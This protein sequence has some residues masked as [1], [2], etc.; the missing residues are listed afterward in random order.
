MWRGTFDLSPSNP[1]ATMRGD[2]NDPTDSSFD[3]HYELEVG[4]VCRGGM[5]RRYLDWD[6]E[7]GPGGVWLCGMWEPHGFTMTRC[8]CTVV[9]MVVS[10]EYL[11]SLGPPGHDWLAPFTATARARPVLTEGSRIAMQRIAVRIQQLSQP[12]SSARTAW[13]QTCL[14]DILLNLT[15]GWCAPE[16]TDTD[17]STLY[18]RL[19]P[20]TALVFSSRRLVTEAEASR[21]CAMSRNIF[22]AHFKQLTGVTFASFALRYRVRSAAQDLAATDRPLKAVAADWGFSD[23][24]H[25]HRVFLRH[26]ACSPSAFRNRARAQAGATAT[27]A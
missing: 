3:M 6:V 17:R 18:S 23:V 1:I 12:D 5:V 2:H 10:P 4:I 27:H 22:C 24:S 26:Y 7:L 9:V 13:L 14:S 16:G 25:L 20:S 11:S 21:A 8:P 15:D 19:S